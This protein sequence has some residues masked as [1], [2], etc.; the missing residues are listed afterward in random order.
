MN[1]SGS[2]YPVALPTSRCA[3]PLSWTQA[4]LGQEPDVLLA[5]PSTSPFSPVGL[6]PGGIPMLYSHLSVGFPVDP[7]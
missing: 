6:S 4:R 2:R 1:D 7:E 5:L 3:R